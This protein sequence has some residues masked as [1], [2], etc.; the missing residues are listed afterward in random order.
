MLY[1]SILN[2]NSEYKLTRSYT[3]NSSQRSSGG[4]RQPSRESQSRTMSSRIWQKMR[5][6]SR[7]RSFR[8]WQQ[9]VDTVEI[10]I[11]LSRC[12]GN[13][14]LRLDDEVFCL[15]AVLEGYAHTTWGQ[16]LMELANHDWAVWFSDTVQLGQIDPEGGN[17]EI[18][19]HPQKNTFPARWE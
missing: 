8:R 9:H 4:R 10:N 3:V 7:N 13:I 11:P 17:W 15:K 16:R 14:S 18:G 19:A 5:W 2:I 6:D 12:A 1:W